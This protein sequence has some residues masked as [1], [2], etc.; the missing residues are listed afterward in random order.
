MNGEER[1]GRD[2]QQDD[3]DNGSASTVA[4]NS[5]IDGDQK[6]HNTSSS[7]YEDNSEEWLMKRAR[8][9]FSDSAEDET[10]WLF[11][12]ARLSFAA[13]AEDEDDE[14]TKHSSDPMEVMPKAYIDEVL[15]EMEKLERG[16]SKKKVRYKGVTSTAEVSGNIENKMEQKE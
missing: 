2:I 1:G 12:R 14:N 11:K 3:N 13:S 6:L 5:N 10:D 7:S 4:D 15:A 16:R 8:K 9:V